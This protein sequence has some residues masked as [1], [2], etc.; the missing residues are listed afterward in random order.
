[1]E[2]QDLNQIFYNS[3]DSVFFLRKLTE[4]IL[5]LKKLL[6]KKRTSCERKVDHLVSPEK[7]PYEPK[8]LCIIYFPLILLC[9]LPKRLYGIFL[10][11]KH[12]LKYHKLL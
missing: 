11:E 6:I 8:T 9:I 12:L 5:L 4:T 1:M 2:K 10:V 7:N 3:D